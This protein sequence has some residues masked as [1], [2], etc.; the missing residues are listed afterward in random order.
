M[1][2]EAY[3]EMSETESNHWWFA[4]R[5]TIL[6]SIIKNLNIPENAQ[7]LEVGCGTGGNLMMLKK[8]GD[9]SA[10]EMDAKARSIAQAKASSNID[11]RYG[12]CP[13]EVPFVNEKQFDL[14]CMFDVLEHIDKDVD[15]LSVLRSMLKPGG[16][17]LITVPAYQWLFGYHDEFLH[18][19]R[20]YSYS[21]I[22]NKV[23]KA[24]YS[25]ERFSFFNTFLFPVVAVVRIKEKLL[26]LNSYT[27]TKTPPKAI[28]ILLKL[29]FTTEKYILKFINMPFGVSIFCLI[30][31]KETT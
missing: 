16:R 7:I 6:E 17:L 25:L 15:T 3:V 24:G 5:R 2:P 10:I 31:P 9:V 23:D 22:K 1:N 18:H 14:I 27:G 20:R 30:K 21:A 19:K 11:I 26:R 8:Y 12:C 28:N 13:S 29:I 4:G